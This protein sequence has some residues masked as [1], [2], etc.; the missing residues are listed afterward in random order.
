MQS[1]THNM[2]AILEICRS[3]SKFVI[4]AILDS[5]LE[6]PLTPVAVAG[7]SPLLAVDVL[8]SKVKSLENFLFGATLTLCG[9]VAKA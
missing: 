3:L 5:S 2:E 1:M 4:A 6:A 9:G 7:T 8:E